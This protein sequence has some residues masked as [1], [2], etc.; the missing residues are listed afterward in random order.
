MWIDGTF[1]SPSFHSVRE[2]DRG[3]GG[4]VEIDTEVIEVAPA[5]RDAAL[6]M[7]WTWEIWERVTAAGTCMID[8]LVRM[9]DLPLDVLLEWF[10]TSG[11]DPSI[12]DH[13]IATLEERGFAVY[14]A[15]PEGFGRFRDYR[16]LVSMFRKNDPNKGHVVLIYENDEGIFDA[17][18]VFKKVSDI[19]FSDM[20]G[21][22]RGPVW[23]IEKKQTAP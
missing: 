17:A 14:A 3:E 19:V 13:V 2:V 12:Q 15:G 20:L 10:R 22:N 6:G 18:G 5:E 1:D 7:I 11:R 9:L 16:R 21:Y 23:R 8:S 4:T